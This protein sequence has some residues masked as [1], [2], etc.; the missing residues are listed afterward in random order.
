MNKIKTGLVTLVAAA[1]LGVAGVGCKHTPPASSGDIEQ[2]DGYSIEQIRED[3]RLVG[4]NWYADGKLVEEI[5]FS[6]DEKSGIVDGQH[7]VFHHDDGVTTETV[8]SY[9]VFQNPDGNYFNRLSERQV[10]VD[11]RLDTVVQ[12]DYDG[13]SLFE[14]RRET[15]CLE[16]TITT[17]NRNGDVNYANIS[18]LDVGNMASR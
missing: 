5:N 12:M 9:E 7:R 13:D 3:G 11:G 16:E 10:F 17:R 6:Y 4:Q 15:D 8:I 2:F 1:M 14:E 18:C